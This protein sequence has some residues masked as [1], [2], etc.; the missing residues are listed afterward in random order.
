[1]KNLF[2]NSILISISAILLI[3]GN[4]VNIWHF[5]CDICREHAMELI[6][7]GDC[8][9]YHE[10]NTHSDCGSSKT[11]YNSR[12]CDDKCSSDIFLREDCGHEISYEEN[13][14]VILDDH[15]TVPVIKVNENVMFT[16][17]AQVSANI[18][19]SG[20]LI[21]NIIFNSVAFPKSGRQILQCHC[22]YRC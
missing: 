13:I 19:E 11:V 20:F 3:F 9:I 7:D 21:S 12:I 5:C 4:S 17:V 22:I 2:K 18:S 8:S 16:L 1:V 10:N 14:S 6:Q 15:I